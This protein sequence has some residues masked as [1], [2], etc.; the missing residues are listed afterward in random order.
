MQLRHL[1]TFMAVAST[2]NVTRA[3]EQVH[4]AQSSVTDQIQALEADL[5]TALF[6]RSRRR[7]QL[8]EPGQRLLEYAGDLLARAEEARAAVADAARLSTG[9]LT[10]GA[11]ETLC[12]NWLPPVLATYQAEH[13]AV[14]LQLKVAGSGE[15]RS[16]VRSGVI[17]VCFT[18]GAGPFEEE[19]QH[20]LV[21]EEGLVIIAPPRHRL[22]G[23]EMIQ[24]EDLAGEP[25]LVTEMGC[26]YRQIFESAFPAG[27]PGR[28]RLAGE[29]SSIAA[30]R[31]LVESGVGYALVP[32]IVAA[33]TGGSLAVSPWGGDVRSVPVSMIWR[34]QR[35]QPLALRHLLE[36]ARQ[37]I[38][39]IRPDDAHP[40]HA[41]RS[42]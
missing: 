14:R 39:T 9:R 25:F 1:K 19:L 11:L 8:T 24:A 33:E 17:D 29:F 36:A 28:P 22:A 5:G 42:L 4:L 3:A 21:A 2:L 30:I 6:D 41:T 32:R 16:A 15:L 34:R 40:R 26:V 7:L 20:E 23:R 13:S 31:R 38:A 18:F 35:V 10:I 37:S 27:Q 12:A